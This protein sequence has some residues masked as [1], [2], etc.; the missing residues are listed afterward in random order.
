MNYCSI[1][2]AWGK[3]DYISEQYR[4]YDNPFDKKN[5]IENFKSNLDTEVGLVDDTTIPSSSK[6]T[7]IPVTNNSHCVVTCKDFFDHLDNCHECR[8]K[9]R[10]RYSSRIVESLKEIVLDNR[11]PLLLFLVV[12]FM[13][14]FTNLIVTICRA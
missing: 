11:E 4:L 3:T 12:L 8:M 13:I 9:M 1:E 6:P 5:N 7:V 14:I 2:D 10:Y